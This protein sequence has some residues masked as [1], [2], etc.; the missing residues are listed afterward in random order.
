[1]APERNHGSGE[2]HIDACRDALLAAHS[3][4]VLVWEPSPRPLGLDARGGS[5]D[6]TP[7]P[8]DGL[9]DPCGNLGTDSAWPE[10]LEEI[11]ASTPF[12][13]ARPWS[14]VRARPRVLVRI[15]RAARGGLPWARSSPWAGVVAVDH[16]R[17]AASVSRSMR[18]PWLVPPGHVLTA[19]VARG[20][21]HHPPRRRA[22]EAARVPR[23][24]RVGALA[25][26]SGGHLPAGAAAI[27]PQH[28]W[29]SMGEPL[30]R[31][32]QRQ[33][34]IRTPSQVLTTG[35]KGV[36][37]MPRP[38]SAGAAGTRSAKR[39]HAKSLHASNVPAMVPSA[40]HAAPSRMER[41]SVG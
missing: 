9:P 7:T 31:S 4:A 2:E 32:P 6:G 29:R 15:C 38:R 40:R 18:S 27:A 13:V 26:G 22:S 39:F 20:Q 35:R 41:I 34:V 36:R 5:W 10:S 33:P 11:V 21:M 23:P 19:A 3:T 8:R 1:M 16:G 14:P 12:A 17:T 25:C 30:G 37:G 24:T 28:A